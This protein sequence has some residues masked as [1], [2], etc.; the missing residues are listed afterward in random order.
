MATFIWATLS[1]GCTY[2]T[3]REEHR[4]GLN[5][6]GPDPYH[7]EAGRRIWAMLLAMQARS[8]AVNL[9]LECEVW[10]EASE[11]TSAA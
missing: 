4:R 7:Q 8:L 2:S 11:A 3:L 10:S 9:Q 6:H 5:R 1:Q